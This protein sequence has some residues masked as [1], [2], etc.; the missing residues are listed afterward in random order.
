M[1]KCGQMRFLTAEAKAAAGRLEGK[2]REKTLTLDTLNPQVKAVE[3][4]VRGP[5]VI[6]AGE[7]ER[8]LEEV[9]NV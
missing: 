7:I 6:K 8:Y 3:Y 4:A 1:E 2:L 9:R 5:I